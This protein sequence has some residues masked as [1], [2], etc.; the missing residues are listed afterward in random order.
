VV[1]LAVR[2]LV[3]T[4]TTD[5]PLSDTAC[6]ASA[7]GVAGLPPQAASSPLDEMIAARISQVFI[8]FDIIAPQVV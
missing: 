2:K 8:P 6:A 1:W 7:D 3:A 4:G 5:A